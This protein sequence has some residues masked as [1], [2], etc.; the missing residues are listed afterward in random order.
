[1]AIEDIS[2]QARGTGLW[3]PDVDERPCGHLGASGIAANCRGC[4]KEVDWPKSSLGLLDDRPDI[5]LGS[6]IPVDGAASISVAVTS[7]RLEILAAIKALAP[8]VTKRGAMARPIPAAA[9][10]T[11]HTLSVTCIA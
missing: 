2:L 10:V 6:D 3:E 4:D 1:M 7:N 5:G 8:L 11:T 9:P